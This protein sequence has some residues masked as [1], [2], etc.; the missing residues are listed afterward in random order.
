MA[1]LET[2]AQCLIR[3]DDQEI[4]LDISGLSLDQYIDSHHFMTVR[5]HHTERGSKA[6]ELEDPAKYSKFLGSNITLSINPEG[7]VVDSSRALEFI[8]IVTDIQF[9]NVVEGTNVVIITAASP[10]ITM[11]GPE[12]NAHYF[13][14]SASDIIGSIVDNYPVTKGDIESTSEKYRFDTQYRETDYDYIMR[15][16]ESV[17]MFAW[18]S[19]S[20]FN[21]TSANSKK[22][23]D[24]KWRE[25]LG[26][27]M[28]NLGT[29][30]VEFRSEVYNY[31][32]NKIF[33]SDSKSI[34]MEASISKLSKVSPD[35]SKKIFEESGFTSFPKNIEDAKTLD[36]TLKNERRLAM[37]SLVRCHGLSIVPEV[38][39]GSCVQVK[40]MDKYDGQ[41]WVIGVQHILSERS[42]YHNTFLCVPLDIA[43]PGR[44][45]LEAREHAGIG[46]HLARV[47]DLEDP[48][49]LGR[50]KIKYPWLEGDQ[51]E[52]ARLA[53]PH[54]GKGRGW[55]VLPEI[56]DEV[57]VG[58]E[59]GD[60]DRPVVLGC[61]YNKDSAP[62]QE[63]V[64]PENDIKMLM[65]RSGNKILLD[66]KDGS[67]KIVISQKD[68][69]NSIVMDMSGPSISISTDGDISIKGKNLGIETD[70]GITM[71]AGADI[72]LEGTNIE[73]K[74]KSSIK[75]EAS[76][77]ND[78]QGGVQ[79]NI[80]GGL[81]NIN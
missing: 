66:D 71:K 34:A 76:V 9:E 38:T 54:A 52:W 29:A 5:I 41:Y 24:L 36:N 27:F 43:Y 62:M 47:V 10:T 70:Q 4:K 49:K 64:S 63:A 78:I 21:L 23:V 69:K 1:V 68:G 59:F 2:P 50:I 45:M 55:Y 74:A 11:D 42:K 40:G 61:L 14:Q 79:V 75:S 32:Q 67:E 18:Y 46:V 37:G 15:L 17:G 22:T 31:E 81:V 20:D 56:D 60:T 44:K 16:A 73:I 72:K 35:A 58:Y 26:S 6:E 3:V 77:K 48:M 57:L 12:R 30:P 33:S 39:V 80:K 7:G 51:T 65:T 8:G 53:V 28:M 25:E 13:N 19:G